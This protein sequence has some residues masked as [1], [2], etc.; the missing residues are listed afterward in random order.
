MKVLR[1]APRD[2]AITVTIV[3]AAIV[4][5]GVRSYQLSRPGMLFG[6][7][8]DISVYLGASVRLVHGALPYRDFVFVQP[9]GF[10]LLASPIAFLSELVGTRDAL[11]ILRLCT[12]FIAAAT[13]LLVGRLVRH[14]GRPAVLV[15]CGVMALFPAELY[16]LSNGLL[17][18][19]LDLFCLVGAALAFDGE[20]LAGRR[21]LAAAGLAFG[22]AGAVKTP[23]ILPVAVVALLCLPELRR[24]LLPF[25]GGV[26]AGFSIPVLPFLLTAPAAFYRDVVTTQL[27]RTAGSG[28]EPLPMRLGDLT[29]VSAFGGGGS[30]AI[31]ATIV[32]ALL[33]VAAFVLSRKRSTALERFAIG[34]T[35]TVA[36]AQLVPAQYYPQYAAFLAPFLAILLGISLD[37]LLRGRAARVAPAVAASAVALLLA[38]TLWYVHRESTRDVA[39]A[40]DA[41]IPAGGCALSDSPRNLVTA[42]RF[43]AAGTDCTTMTDPFGTTLAVGGSSSGAEQFWRATFAHVDY[44]VSDT[45]IDR[46]YIAPA[47]SLLAY[48][49]GNFRLVHSG[50][51]MI[52]VRNGFPAG[53]PSS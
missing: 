19:L 39:Q 14:R 49:A 26:I 36:A 11:A 16:A 47:P 8:A 27:A 4:A 2:R 1:R 41:V 34:A 20:H 37:R 46:W 48:I 10:V 3:A 12:P 22:F 15:A 13:V 24:R 43:V 28:R 21:R 42:D 40:I 30:A 29:G 50:G 45:P 32:L 33:V 44:V 52:Y 35:V 51:L 23:A 5:A 18:P 38:F 31:T 9:P 6:T 25:A 53:P 7:T 17:E